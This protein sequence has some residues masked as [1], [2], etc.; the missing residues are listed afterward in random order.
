M[1]GTCRNGSPHYCPNCDRHIYEVE[2]DS[3]LRAQVQALQEVVT[4]GVDE[5]WEETNQE[6]VSKARAAVAALL[7]A[8]KEQ[9]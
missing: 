6:T 2:E 4:E 7:A 5:Y 8:P 9:P 3:A 1:T